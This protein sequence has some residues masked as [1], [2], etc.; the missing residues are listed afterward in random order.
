MTS[1]ESWRD[2]D[3]SRLFLDLFRTIDAISERV[4]VDEVIV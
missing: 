2:D 3:L 1:H 4:P